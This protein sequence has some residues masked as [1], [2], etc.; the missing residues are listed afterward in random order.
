MKSSI[1]TQIVATR[2]RCEAAQ[3][4]LPHCELEKNLNLTL[5]TDDKK[6]LMLLEHAIMKAKELKDQLASAVQQH[7]SDT[8]DEVRRCQEEVV[9]SNVGSQS[10]AKSPEHSNEGTLFD[11]IEE[12]L[13]ASFLLDLQK[14]KTVENVIAEDNKP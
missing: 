11:T 14:Y 8:I 7:S 4:L 13:P 3:S 12:Y 9:G 10:S 2:A 1:V 5:E 6:L